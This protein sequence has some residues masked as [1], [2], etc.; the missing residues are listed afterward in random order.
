MQAVKRVDV[1]IL[2]F[3]DETNQQHCTLAIV[4]DKHVHLLEGRELGLSK[5]TTPKGR[6]AQWL[7]QA[8][9]D[10]LAEAEKEQGTDVAADNAKKGKK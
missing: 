2:T 10:K 8:I 1:A 6:G 7:A 5:N 4:G 9:F 3:T